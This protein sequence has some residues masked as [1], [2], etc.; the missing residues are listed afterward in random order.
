MPLSKLLNWA[1]EWDDGEKERVKDDTPV[2]G[3]CTCLEKFTG[4]K[5]HV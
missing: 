2:T 4:M 1:R 3:L 5:I